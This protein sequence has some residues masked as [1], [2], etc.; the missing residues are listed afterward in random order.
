MRER[1]GGAEGPQDNADLNRAR[2]QLLQVN[3]LE[4]Q[5]HALP[6]SPQE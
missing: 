4:E 1:H 5:E 2:T 6:Y 3:W